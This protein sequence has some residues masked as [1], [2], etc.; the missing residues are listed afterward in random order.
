MRAIVDSA[1]MQLIEERAFASGETAAGLMDLV[2]SQLAALLERLIAR[3]PCPPTILLLAGKGNNGADGYTALSLL[4]S[5]N[6]PTLALQIAPPSTGSLAHARQKTY[7]DLGGKILFFPDLPQV[8]G[9]LII[10]D[11]I[12]GIGFK[13]K[14]DEASSKAI[15]WANAHCGIR[16]SIDIPSGVNATTG[17]IPDEAIRAEYTLSCQFPKK[18]CFI[19]SG[20]DYAGK[21]VIADLPLS[22]P[23]SDLVLLE[24]ADVS[25]LLPRYRRTQNKYE[26]GSV[27][28]IAGSPGM[29]G[30]VSLACEASYMVGSGYVRL[31]L[32]QGA[33]IG[34]LP[35]EVV[36]TFLSDD[37]GEY[38][39]WCKQADATF[40]GPGLGRDR[41][42]RL[43]Q[44]WPYLPPSTVVDADALY[45]L[46]QKEQ[47][48]WNV[49]GKILTPHRGEA[50]RL[51][52]KKID[53]IDDSLLQLFRTLALTSKSTI[54]L[55]GAPTF[56]FSEKSPIIA[57]PRGLPS[58]S[59]AMLA[60]WLHG[61]AGERAATLRTSYSL[62]ASS[63]IESLPFAIKKLTKNIS[64]NC[65]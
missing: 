34:D 4:F 33:E 12:Y 18:G 3:F 22:L 58:L 62:T 52:Q 47:K 8:E 53:H 2:G 25:P 46:A 54:L 49:Q 20:W 42:D 39:K 45:W 29:M 61:M 55:K 26:V 24:E 31:L 56:I 21:I 27:V 13:G 35:R 5:K 17:E 15:L 38:S 48:E 1:T 10:I 28:G 23:K 44:L 11:G 40:V 6:L 9:P 7:Q 65:H 14:P 30:A 43:D 57:M 50:G 19:G 32:P 59:A 16:V 64:T 63:L 36:K 51:V 41:L 37:I 60:A